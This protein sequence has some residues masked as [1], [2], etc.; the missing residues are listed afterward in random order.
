MPS[1]LIV[2][3]DFILKK[4]CVFKSLLLLLLLFLLFHIV[5]LLFIYIRCKFSDLYHVCVCVFT[6]AK[7]LSAISFLSKSMSW[8]PCV[9]MLMRARLL[10]SYRILHS[11]NQ[12]CEIANLCIFIVGCEQHIAAA[13]IAIQQQQ[14]QNTMHCSLC[15]WFLDL[16]TK[17]QIGNSLKATKTIHW[18]QWILCCKN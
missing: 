9:F 5:H 12:I 1:T 11:N 8:A 13:A 6:Q 2:Y 14:Q 15:V 3:N 17:L 10:P 16:L 7:H 18:K 4:S